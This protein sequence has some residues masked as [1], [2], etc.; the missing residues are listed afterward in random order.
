MFPAV[1]AALGL[2]HPVTG[3]VLWRGQ[4]FQTC[5]N[6][7]NKFFLTVPGIFGFPLTHI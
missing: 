2:L 5:T 6:I 3:E 7:V 1:G 4:N